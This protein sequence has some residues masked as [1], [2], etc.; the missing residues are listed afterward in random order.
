MWRYIQSC[1]DILIVSAVIYKGFSLLVGTRAIQLVKGLMVM[2]VVW[3]FARLFE[4]HLLSWCLQNILPAI[5]FALPIVFQPEL[6]KLLEEIG[7]GNM[8]KGGMGEESALALSREIVAALGYMKTNRI[9]ALLVLQHDTGLK[10]YWRT[11]VMLNARISQELLISIFWKNN[12]LHDGAVIM[13]RSHLIAGSCYLPL[14]DNP[15]IPRWCGTR[16]RA[17][18]GITEVSDAM[19][20]VVSE[21]R[22]EVALA[23][24]GYLSKNLKDTQ[25]EKLLMTYFMKTRDAKSKS[26]M[27]KAMKFFRTKLPE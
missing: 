6:R 24:K 14:A 13:D 8:W 19:V 23:Y 7:G 22:G 3:F 18:L 27:D 9:G 26:F 4:F 1:I 16:H 5:V 12:P 15:D 2:G 10:D 25:V 20:L 21:E 11:A 17:A